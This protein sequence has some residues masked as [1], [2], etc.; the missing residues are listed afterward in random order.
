MMK[1]NIV[2][3][4]VEG[5]PVAKGRPRTAIRHTKQGKPYAHVY[6]PRK[7]AKWEEHVRSRTSLYAFKR[8]ITP[9]EK[10]PVRVD[11]IFYLP[12]PKNMTKKDKEALPF[13]YKKPDLDNLVKAVLDAMEGVFY[14]NDSQR[15]ISETKKRYE[16]RGVNIATPPGVFIRVSEIDGEDMKVE[17]ILNINEKEDEHVDSTGREAVGV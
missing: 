3:L 1:K 10:R 4:F 2:E 9:V 15:C 14:K 5:V 12:K 8:G 16:W 7:T 6:T 11:L 13:H 17:K